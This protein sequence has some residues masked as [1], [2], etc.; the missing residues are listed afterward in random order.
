MSVRLLALSLLCA[1]STSIAPLAWAQAKNAD[2]GYVP[3]RGQAG[4][5]VIWIPTPQGLIDKML[6]V[7]RVGSGDLVYDLGAGDG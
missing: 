7:A 5:D 6:D 2:P 3:Q 4:K 1:L